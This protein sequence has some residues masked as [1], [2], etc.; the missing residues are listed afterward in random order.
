V[1]PDVTAAIF[2]LK[3]CVPQHCATASVLGK[4][5]ISDRPITEEQWAKE[6]A[7]VIDAEPA[8]TLPKD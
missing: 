1:P 3:N 4:Y 6:R 5:M 2:G 8:P 7:T